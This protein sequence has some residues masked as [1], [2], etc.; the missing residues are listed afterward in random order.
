M[1]DAIDE[2]KQK[3]WLFE[4]A[5]VEE[6]ANAAGIDAEGLKAEL[7]RYMA[8]CT[9]VKDEDFGRDVK[10]TA[11]FTGGRLFAFTTNSNVLATVGG[12]CIDENCSVLDVNDNPM[13]WRNAWTDCAR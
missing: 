13:P 5:S 11:P 12:L 1:E 10:M 6:L 2:F 3:G 8:F 7:D 9:A 4:G